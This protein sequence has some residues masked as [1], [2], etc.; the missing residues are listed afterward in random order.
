[1]QN[2]I[3]RTLF[4]QVRMSEPIFSIISFAYIYKGL[5]MEGYALSKRAL[6][7]PEGTGK[8]TEETVGATLPAIMRSLQVS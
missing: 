7:L 1:M 2:L 5:N 3:Q 8:I 4:E 6:E